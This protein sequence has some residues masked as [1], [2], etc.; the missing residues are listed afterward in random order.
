MN[1]LN[2]VAPSREGWIILS[3][4][5]ASRINHI[6]DF[7]EDL[8]IGIATDII[9][10]EAFHGGLSYVMEELSPEPR[11]FDE[12]EAWVEHS[13]KKA[14]DYY[15]QFGMCPFLRADHGLAGDDPD[16]TTTTTT[17]T[18]G[19]KAGRPTKPDGGTMRSDAGLTASE[20][21]VSGS[22][23]ATPQKSGGGGRT[24]KDS[25]LKRFIIPSIRSGHFLARM[26]FDGQIEVGFQLYRYAGSHHPTSVFGRQVAPTPGVHVFVWPGRSPVPD[27]PTPF[28]SVVYRLLPTQLNMRELWRN[29]MDASHASTHPSLVLVRARGE[30][31][32]GG[33]MDQETEMAVYADALAMSGPPT[34]EHE[35]STRVD[36]EFTTRL[37][38]QLRRMR[39]ASGGGSRRMGVD[40]RLVGVQ[41]IRYQNWEC[42]NVF[43]VP[44]GLT[45][46]THPM[47]QREGDIIQRSEWWQRMVAH[48]FGVP[49]QYLDRSSSARDPRSGGG[50]SASLSAGQTDAC[51][52]LRKTVQESRYRMTSF[53]ESAYDT[54]FRDEDTERVSSK[55]L[56]GRNRADQRSAALRTY[57]RHLSGRPDEL[58]AAMEQ[59]QQE[60]MR[61]MDE[62]SKL[63]AVINRVFNMALERTSMALDSAMIGQVAREE[64]DREKQEISRLTTKVLPSGRRIRI[65]WKQPVLVDLTTLNWLSDKGFIHDDSMREIVLREVGLPDD[66][67]QGT[68]I[69]ERML[70][71]QQR[72]GDTAGG[73]GGGGG[74]VDTT[75]SQAQ[76]ITAGVKRSA[77]TRGTKKSS[78][79]KEK[80]T[81]TP[82]KKKQKTATTGKQ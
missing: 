75:R 60:E 62:E 17:T 50:S 37:Q 56:R 39:E 35:R 49:M 68:P 34:I 13:M 14:L 25:S 51:S 78:T 63:R 76:K 57:E 26:T 61:W 59:R 74:V 53:F 43:A 29:D 40:D 23:P 7:S 22:M 70:I 18:K 65:N 9:K 69:E 36:A 3:P 4:H 77:T 8:I 12:A 6:F 20:V 11:D 38:M 44:S 71:L 5:I 2:T 54:L 52:L 48:Q 72:F 24:K 45:T 16:T 80:T 19:K 73:G 1:G 31:G 28:R 79:A 81:T 55:I 32:F 64:L 33:T 10:R 15:Y 42:G 58:Q 30:S 47:P 67:P 82:K 46:A 21:G 41:V 27:S 66:T